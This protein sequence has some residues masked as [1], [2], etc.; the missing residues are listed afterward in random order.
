MKNDN[1][2][3]LKILKEA[4]NSEEG[5]IPVYMKHLESALFWTGIHPDNVSKAKTILRRL[6]AEST[7]H[8]IAVEKLIARLEGGK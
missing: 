7:A 2:E 4:R 1:N 6:A 8:K 5:V 3:M